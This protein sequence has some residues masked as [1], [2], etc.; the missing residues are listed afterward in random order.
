MKNNRYLPLGCGCALVLA[1]MAFHH[2][3]PAQGQVNTIYRGNNG[4]IRVTLNNE[5]IRFPDQQ[6]V[7]ID[8]RVLVPLRGVFQA[9]GATVEWNPADQTIVARKA[10]RTVRLRAG[11]ADASVN[12]R[13]V[14][15]DVPAQMIGGR[16][17]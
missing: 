5:P 10:D 15:L 4:R 11:S 13:P 12:R 2:A 17:M 8:N 16:V 14:S 9:L 6:P 1:A 7:S 3:P